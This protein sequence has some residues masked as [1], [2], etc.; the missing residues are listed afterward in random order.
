MLFADDL[1]GDG[2]YKLGYVT[3]D[4]D[5]AIGHFKTALGFGEFLRFDPSPRLRRSDGRSG[6]ARLRCA[7]STGRERVIELMQP[8]DGLVDLWSAPLAGSEDRTVRFHHI[9][10]IVSDL[11]AVTKRAAALGMPVLQQSSVPGVLSVAYLELPGLGHYVELV[12][13]DKGVGG[14][15]SQARAMRAQAVAEPGR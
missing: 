12:Q 14:V 1:L 13:Y 6:T 4:L 7:F 9:G 3:N 5:W 8:V 11:E 10:S 15:L 2:F